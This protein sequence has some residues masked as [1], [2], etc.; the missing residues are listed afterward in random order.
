MSPN[1]PANEAAVPLCVDLDGTIVDG[2]TTVF[3]LQN[4]LRTRPFGILPVFWALRRGR[5]FFKDTLF[6]RVRLRAEALPF[7]AEIVAFL[8]AEH[9]AGRT[10]ILSTAAN[11]SVASLIADYLGVFQSVIASD[12]ERNLKGAAKADA[13]V[14]AFGMKGFD[15]MG[16]DAVDI[17]VW[18]VARRAYVVSRHAKLVETVRRVADVAGVFNGGGKK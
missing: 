14:R 16:N 6:A 10:V 18:T 5:A 11:H 1:S 13:L 9:A 17:P 12:A 8:R 15:Y 2:D 4:L 7:R 3:A